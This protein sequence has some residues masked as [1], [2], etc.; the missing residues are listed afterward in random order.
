MSGPLLTRTGA[1]SILAEGDFRETGKQEYPDDGTQEDIGLH[2]HKMETPQGNV[3]GRDQKKR[4]CD[5]AMHPPASRGVRK[6]GHTHNQE[7]GNPEQQLELRPVG[8]D[9]ESDDG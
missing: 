7:G 2:R 4:P 6:A 3:Y 1:L 5:I 8:P 9:N